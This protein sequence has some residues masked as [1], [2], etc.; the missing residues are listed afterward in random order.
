MPR[1]KDGYIKEMQHAEK[2]REREKHVLSN[3]T[4]SFEPLLEKVLVTEEDCQWKKKKKRVGLVR[5]TRGEK[6]N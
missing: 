5:S 3:N 4:R 6:K 2:E 1:R